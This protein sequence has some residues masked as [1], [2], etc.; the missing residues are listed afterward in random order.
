MSFHCEIVKPTKSGDYTAESHESLVENHELYR[1]ECREKIKPL[2]KGVNN[3]WCYFQ[4]LAEREGIK[5][6]ANLYSLIETAKANVLEPYAYLWQVFTE[7]P[8]VD[9][10]APPLN[11]SAC[12]AGV[13]YQA[14][15]PNICWR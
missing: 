7:L 11:G 12:R 6:S 2:I 15:G 13:S 10:Y 9:T 5:A 1:G 14:R 8:K 4:N 3:S